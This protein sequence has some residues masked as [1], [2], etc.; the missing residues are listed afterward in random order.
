MLSLMIGF[1]AGILAGLAIGLEKFAKIDPNDPKMLLAIVAAGYAG[2]DFIENAF[3]NL[4]PRTITPP[5][6]RARC[7]SPPIV[8]KALP[9]KNLIR[10]PV[11]PSS[12]EGEVPPYEPTVD[13]ANLKAALRDV[14]PR[15][16]T[17]I[18]YRRFP[19]PS[20]NLI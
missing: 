13:S 2:T 9:K 10:E 6:L 14:A 16:N 20:R 7:E 15:V 8:T 3:T 5:Q 4:V 17:N 18:G 11:L 12:R 1:T 19:A